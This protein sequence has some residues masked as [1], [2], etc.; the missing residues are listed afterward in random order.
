MT[1]T[2]AGL[3]FL[4]LLC[5]SAFFSATETAFFA[6]SPLRLK[7]LEDDGDP[8]A[9]EILRI[10]VDKQ[11]I[12]ITLLL[13]NTFVNVIATAMAT[14]FFL[15]FKPESAFL[16]SLGLGTRPGAAIAAASLVMTI[17]I[18]F[19][20]E[21]APKTVAI[22]NALGFARVVIKPLRALIFLLTP[23]TSLVI[24]LLKVVFPSHAEWNRKLGSATWA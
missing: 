9:G 11:R 12:L 24:G 19:C 13:G 1:D 8:A 2:M 4:G 18:L 14:Q 16:Q 5:G 15:N 22:F 21:I 3:A 10:L 17:V 23:V 7:K 20:G 6:L